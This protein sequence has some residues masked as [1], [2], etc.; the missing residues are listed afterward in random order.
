M[1]GIRR[2]GHDQWLLGSDTKDEHVCFTH[3]NNFQYMIV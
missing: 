3:S 2:G 1:P